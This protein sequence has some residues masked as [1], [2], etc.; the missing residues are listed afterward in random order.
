MPLANSYEYLLPSPLSSLL[1]P[2]SPLLY[3]LS[4]IIS[5]CISRATSTG[6][7][8]H[9]I[10]SVFPIICL[11]YTFQS[12]EPIC[13]WTHLY[14]HQYVIFSPILLP[15]VSYPMPPLSSYHHIPENLSS[16]TSITTHTTNR[17]FLVIYFFPLCSPTHN[18][19]IQH[20]L[21][22]PSIWH[23]TT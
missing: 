16:F 20:K 9:Y 21:T 19:C 18:L 15:L 4:S 8:F 23:L 11:F 22:T 1:S 17:P 3:P 10:L 14:Y 7:L 5:V 12:I 13:I 6:V 2:L